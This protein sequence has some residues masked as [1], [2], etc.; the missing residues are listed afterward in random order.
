MLKVP[1]SMI[2]APTGSSERIARRVKGVGL[3]PV[4][5]DN[6]SSGRG[7]GNP[8]FILLLNGERMKYWWDNAG[9]FTL[10]TTP[11]KKLKLTTKGT[12]IQKAIDQVFSEMETAGFVWR[13]HYWIS[14]WWFSP[15]GVP[16]F[17]VPFWPLHPRLNQLDLYVDDESREHTYNE[18]LNFV[19]HEIGHAF[20]NAYDTKTDPL[21]IE[22]FGDSRDTPY[23]GSYQ[24]VGRKRG[25]VRSNGEQY[26]HIHP[27][28]D[29]AETFAVCINPKA[30]FI[31]SD[32]TAMAKVD[33]MM[34]LIDKHKRRPPKKTNRY[35]CGD[36]NVS[37]MTLGS[38]YAQVEKSARP[39]DINI[40]QEYLQT[41][42]NTPLS[43][44]HISE[45]TRPY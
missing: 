31:T 23:P 12:R 42:P 21:R 24:V 20:E 16:G 41:G 27:C 17:A 5:L 7:R 1:F 35:T 29:F 11:V 10:F 4:I 28:E 2:R 38:F 26:G 45:P 37:D 43:L 13:P 36:L 40:I 19:R 18:E 8:V 32:P 25:F 6:L 33:A 44:I 22:A 9:N 15:D 14:T 3:G 39:L 30:R 34:V